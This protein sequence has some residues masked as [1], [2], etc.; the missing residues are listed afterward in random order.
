MQCILESA[1]LMMFV[2]GDNNISQHCGNN[3]EGLTNN[4]F[5]AWASLYLFTEA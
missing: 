5:S 3:Q 2:F 4:N 1:F